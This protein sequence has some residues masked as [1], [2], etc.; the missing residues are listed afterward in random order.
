MDHP[1]FRGVEP[2]CRERDG[3][4]YDNISLSYGLDERGFDSRQGLGIFLFTTASRPAL[5][6]TQP[7]IQCVAGAVYLVVKWPGREADYSPP[8]NAE[9]K[10]C[11]ELHFH[12]PNTPRWRSAQL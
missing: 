4:F 2:T 7:L 11:L 5:G 8:S 10:E 6:T 9:V 1:F 12:S 3:K